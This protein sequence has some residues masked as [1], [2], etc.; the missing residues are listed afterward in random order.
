MSDRPF[1]RAVQEWLEGGSD[2]TPPAAIQAVLFAVKTTPQQRDL[3]VPRRFNLMPAYL[4]LAAAAVVVAVVLGAVF[5]NRG[6][7]QAGVETGPV[8]SP[9][10]QPSQSPGPTASGEDPTLQNAPAASC[11]G[12]TDRLLCLEPGT[13]QLGSTALWPAVVTFDV[14]E[15]WWYYEGSTAL[16]GVLVQ[17]ED[18]VDGSGWGVTF[19]TVGT[20][21]RDPCRR[22][23]GKIAPD[24]V[25][26]ASELAAAM[27]AWP[28][29]EATLSRPV[30]GQ[31]YPGVAITLLSGPRAEDCPD[32][33]MFTTAASGPVDA[34]P[35][36][37]QQ[38]RPHE[39]EFRI[40]EIEGELLVVAAMNFPET[41]PFEEDNG[42]PFDP[43]RHVEHQVEM[44][45]ILD[46]IELKDPNGGTN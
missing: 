26:T 13:Y 2:R 3:W 42:V 29:F 40:F 33:L 34:Y 10:P 31:A 4:R 39:T 38:G 25:D 43:T 21:S 14:P 17:T 41:S 8:V 44:D 1:E 7:D 5:I 16:V 32:N 35:L 23:A 22:S 18:A 9:T 15:N 20:V 46:S 45:A 6:N 37:N 12:I 27:T 30:Y 28:G 11:P 24:E 19:S 36:V